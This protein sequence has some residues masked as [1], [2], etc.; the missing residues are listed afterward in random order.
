MSSRFASLQHVIRSSDP[1]EDRRRSARDLVD[2]ISHMRAQGRIQSVRIINI[3]MHGLMCR[4]D[5]QIAA[6]EHVDLWLPLL[7][8]Y[9][10]EVRWSQEGRVGVEFKTP[11]APDLYAR[12]LPL[13][14]PRRTVW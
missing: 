4:T 7:N 14:P 10:A 2:M 6:G 1:L 11:V 12:M 5:A 13:I 9:P 8:D 3:S